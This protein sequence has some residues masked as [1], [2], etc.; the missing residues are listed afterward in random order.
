LVHQK[1]WLDKPKYDAAEK[2]YYERLA[3]IDDI[4]VTSNTVSVEITNR[5]SSLEK[6]NVDLKNQVSE[7]ADLSKKMDLRI[8]SLEVTCAGPSKP[9][10]YKA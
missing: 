1:I 4:A 10:D 7:L 3:K 6:E 5:L 2:R 9:T 8:S